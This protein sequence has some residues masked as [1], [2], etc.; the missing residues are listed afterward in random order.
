MEGVHGVDVSWLHHSHKD[1][2]PH[3]LSPSASNGS[4]VPA[5]RDGTLR[6]AKLNDGES[7]DQASSKANGASASQDHNHFHKPH[8]LSRPSSEKLGPTTAH[9]LPKSPQ[10]P[11]ASVPSSPRRRTSWISSIS[12]KFT[13][14]EN[15]S[16]A[17]PQSASSPTAKPL[18][19]PKP[20]PSPT[21]AASPSESKDT[22]HPEAPTPQP[23]QSP[24]SGQGSFIQNAFRRLS[25][26]SGTVTLGRATGSGSICQR[27]VMNIDP[28]RARCQIEDLQPAKLRRVA[29]CV[30]VEIA[31]AAKYVYDDDDDSSEVL[32]PPD[33]RPNLTQLEN[34]AEARKQKDK[35][36]KE[37]GEGE[38]LKYPQ[39]LTDEKE[40]K[41]NLKETKEGLASY[42]NVQGS[43]VDKVEGTENKDSS[44]KREKKKRSE[45]ERKERKERRKREAVENGSIPIERSKDDSSAGD[46][47]S[48]RASTPSKPQDRPTTDPVRIYRR[49]CQLRET[50]ILRRITE[51]LSSSDPMS[52]G[53]ILCLDLS[54]YW[55]QLP[56]LITLGD[57]L[58]VV[59]V[60]KLILEN[61]G[62]TDEA[63]RVVLAGLLAAKTPDQARHNKHIA[64]KAIEHQQGATER[65][66]VIE[67][68]SLKNNPRLGRD[69]WRHIGLFIHMSRSLKAIDL[70]MIPFPRPITSS[71]SRGSPI[72]S[73]GTPKA[74]PDTSM[75]FQRAL[76]TRPAGS[77]L[78][79][80]VMAECGLDS[81]DIERIVDGVI[82]CGSTRLGLANN[83]I[84][85]DGLQHVVRYV[86]M[87]KCEGL[88]LG[89]NDLSNDL[90]ILADALG[91]KNALYALSLADCTLS[92]SSLKPLFPALVCLPNFRFIDLSHNRNLFSTQP[93]ALGLLR[94]YL[95]Q[96][97]V[98]K[99]VHLADVDLS[100]E[101]AIALA[102]VLPE[103]PSLAHLNIL[104]N[105]QL[106][107]L[108]SAKDEASQEEACALY[109]SLMAAVRV[110]NSIVCIDVDV[111]SPD[112]SEIVKAMAKQVVAYSLRNMERGPVAEAYASAAASIADPHGGEKYVNV[113][114]V[115]LHLVGHVDG[116]PENDDSDEP[117]PDEDYI[118]G[119]TGLVKALGVCLGN[120]AI[121]YRRSSKD[122]TPSESG[123]ITP[124]HTLQGGEMTKGKAK[125]M[126]KHLL[127]SART[128]RLRLSPALVR[129]AQNGND[130]G[131]KGFRADL[132]QGRLQFL[133]ST[134]ERMIQRFEDEYP[135][136]RTEP[137]KTLVTPDGTL[138]DSGSLPSPLTNPFD[139]NEED[140]NSNSIVGDAT[141]PSED[142][143]GPV[144]VPISRHNSDVS[145]ASRHLSQEEG[146]MHRF[147]QQIRRNILKPQTQDYAHGRT[148]GEVEAIHLQRL[149]EKLEALD[150][151]EI[152]DK[153][154]R[155]GP[156]AVLK[157]I[158]ATAEE[159]L[160]LEKEDPEAFEKFKESHLIAQRNL[161]SGV[162]DQE[163]LG[164]FEISSTHSNDLG[165]QRASTPAEARPDRLR[166]NAPGCQK[167]TNIVENQYIIYCAADNAVYTYS[168]HN[169]VTT[170]S[171]AGLPGVSASTTSS[172]TSSQQSSSSSSIATSLSFTS[173]TSSSSATT[174]PA[175]SHSLP[176]GTIAA[177]VIGSV[178]GSTIFLLL[179][180]FCFL[181]PYLARKRKDVPHGTLGGAALPPPSPRPTKSK[182]SLWRTSNS[183]P[184]RNINT[185]YATTNRAR[186]QSEPGEMGMLHSTEAEAMSARI[187][188][189]WSPASV[190]SS[191]ELD[192]VALMHGRRD[193]DDN[194]LNGRGGLGILPG[195]PTAR[196]ILEAEDTSLPSQIPSHSHSP[197]RIPAQ[198][199]S[200]TAG[201]PYQPG[202][203]HESMQS[204]PV[205]ES[206]WLDPENSHEGARVTPTSPVSAGSGSGNRWAEG[207]GGMSARGSW[208]GYLSPEMAMAG[209]WRGEEEGL[210]EADEE[211]A[212]AE[213]ED[214]G[215]DDGGQGTEKGKG[216]GK[217]REG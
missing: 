197:P 119:G 27:K 4:T 96:M 19:S 191:A 95:P 121:D 35:K 10:D 132:G 177:I 194:Y 58:A 26:S 162:T 216:K 213:L 120:K 71:N 53:T 143:D 126:S 165:G 203:P 178:L 210:D 86:R 137:P 187:S 186:D 17:T 69:G 144:K 209:G 141:I 92:A 148:G 49:C 135:E 21:G 129:E 198:H 29:F 204:N 184:P 140:L 100:S 168:Y 85:Q 114:D 46:S 7:P 93:N 188:E 6:S 73:P 59:P 179:L 70:S 54:N 102:E 190:T 142:E 145:L 65:L 89:G 138:S 112:S 217:E 192:G 107:A 196:Y 42:S 18:A 44:R 15:Q 174:N 5:A 189:P 111:P 81:D 50:P 118:V 175:P 56:D 40:T 47:S 103:S 159:L 79:E 131:Y 108:A 41:G 208:K 22:K 215:G 160:L 11:K 195:T 202:N 55:M 166:S 124:K 130:M 158:G 68:L 13:S 9:P 201:A 206:S 104:E 123:T 163:A 32:P 136:C 80:L 43:R 48:P 45:E 156:D 101:H 127:G 61:C 212:R 76:G 125:E 74:A 154:D 146:R 205:S 78:E 83:N 115:L 122:I 98:L 164:I 67:K 60:R 117:A 199:F 97:P 99:R 193:P 152:K 170:G 34:Q 62:L 28:Y 151:H 88:D 185:A 207:G 20:E 72:R 33:R 14:S 91:N 214:N 36:V 147:G 8:L 106:T 12:S 30:D 24:K 2:R 180:Y 150:G 39:L 176:T 153:V 51:Q 1:R 94:R 182:S 3:K 109:A 113:P 52:P 64:K 149:R 23:P 87:G 16:A 183:K 31:S 38:A 173:A 171:T 181:R 167:I 169:L 105:P 134:L 75:L 90:H 25:S 157:E 161:V 133:D 200:L 57:Y 82:Q 116:F 66:G 139:P 84:T 211:L 155:M 63:V 77:R 172:S 37:R 110:S 128:I